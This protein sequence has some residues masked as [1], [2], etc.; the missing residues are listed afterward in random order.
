MSLRHAAKGH[1][2]FLGPPIT[3]TG[4]HGAPPWAVTRACERAICSC[5][6]T[7]PIAQRPIFS[8]SRRAVF[9]AC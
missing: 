8:G 1:V 3:T 5:S 7:S 2:L 4:F 9:L 6:R